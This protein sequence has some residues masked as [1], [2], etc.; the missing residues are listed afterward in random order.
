MRLPDT[1]LP[2][3][4]DAFEVQEAYRAL[5]GHALRIE[6]YADDGSAG[7]RQPLH[8]HR[9]ELHRPLP[10]APWARNLHAVFFVASARGAVVPLRARRGRPAGQPRD[11]PGDRRLRQRAAQRLD[12]LP[13]PRRLPA[14]GAG[15]VRRPPSRCSPTTRPGCTSGAPSSGY[16]NAI[17]DLA[18]WPDAYRA[19]LPAAADAAEIT[20]VAP[21]VKGT[22]ITSLFTFDEIDGPGGVWPTVWTG[23][24]D[25][26]YEAI[27]ASDV[28]GTGAPAAAPT[29]RFV[30]QPAGPATA[31]TT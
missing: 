9:A 30:A 14:A 3:G 18:T 24:H 1:V 10:A 22:G 4:L 8:R 29:R 23:A 31:A 2:D 6:T 28:D 5:K 17:D 27:P 7:G 25:V 20:G 26:A 19:P 15:A 13:A 11:H 16:T 21:S 12:R